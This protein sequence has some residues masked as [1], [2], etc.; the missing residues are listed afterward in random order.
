[1]IKSIS[2]LFFQFYTANAEFL[3]VLL[4]SNKTLGAAAVV[5][6]I[7]SQINQPLTINICLPSP[8]PHQPQQMATVKIN[9]QQMCTFIFIYKHIHIR[10]CV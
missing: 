9:K 8:H 6:A 4:D 1:M 3:H 5:I 10:V 7:K 2:L